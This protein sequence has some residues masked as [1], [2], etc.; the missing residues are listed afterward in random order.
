MTGTGRAGGVLT[1]CATAVFL[2]IGS[3]PAGASTIGLDVLTGTMVQQT[4]NRP[5]IIG[6]PSCHN[7]DGFELT[8]LAPNDEA[9]TY[10]SPEYTVGQIRNV[11]GGNSF[12]V[13]LDLNQAP[14]QNGGTYTLESFKLAVDGVTSYST[15]GSTALVPVH[16]GNGYSDADIVMFNLSGLSDAQKLVFTAS[17]SGAIS[18]REQF[19]LA[20]PGAPVPEPATMLLLGSGLAG[21]AA[22]RRRRAKI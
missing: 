12:F 8:L 17:F 4:E 7:P 11:V 5:C 21:L 20:S 13:G 19:F 1:V 10:S 6:D 9:G 16:T 2:T 14:G 3:S 18:G 22:V 15:T